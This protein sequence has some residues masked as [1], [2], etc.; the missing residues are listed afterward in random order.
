VLAAASYRVTRLITTDRFPPAIA[1]R[2]WLE[3]RVPPA[4]AHGV[5]CPHCIGFWVALAAVAITETATR[6]GH[7]HRVRLAAAPWAIATAIGIL[8][9]HEVH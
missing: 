9:D 1:A 3:Q 7:L 6:R 2:S 4:Y 8:A 5:T